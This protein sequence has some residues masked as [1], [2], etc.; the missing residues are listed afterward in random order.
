MGTQNCAE[1][2]GGTKIL[3]YR[4]GRTTKVEETEQFS[5]SSNSIFTH[6][7]LNKIHGFSLK[8]QN[9]I[10]RPQIILPFQLLWMCECS[11]L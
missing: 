6:E 8:Y 11:A 4:E 7:I 1:S 10:N 9:T 3:E 5:T 2:E